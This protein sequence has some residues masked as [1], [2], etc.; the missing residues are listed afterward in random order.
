MHSLLFQSDIS[1]VNQI[2]K[3]LGAMV[4]EQGE[5]ID[6]IEASVEKTEVFVGEGT[7]QLRQA[8]NYQ[9]TK[10]YL[11]CGLFNFFMLYHISLLNLCCQTIH[12]PQFFVVKLRKM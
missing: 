6:S 9:V 5:V 7:S 3:E 2:F 4:H 1:D 12:V 11:A 10:F 8:G